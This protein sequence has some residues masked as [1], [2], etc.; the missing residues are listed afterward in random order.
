MESISKLK[1]N[2]SI[3]THYTTE[4]DYRKGN[5][6]THLMIEHNDDMNLHNQLNK[7]IGGNTW[8]EDKSGLDEVRINQGKWGE[9]HTHQIWDE[10]GFKGYI[11]KHELVKTLF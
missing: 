4:K 2:D 10:V 8:G 7:F 11:N 1:K 3:I 6:H 5:Y 9:I